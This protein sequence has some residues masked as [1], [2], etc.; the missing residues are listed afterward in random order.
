[1]DIPQELYGLD[2]LKIVAEN[3]WKTLEFKYVFFGY[4]LKP[5]YFKVQTVVSMAEGQLTENF[6]Y[7]LEGTPCENVFSGKRVCIHSHGVARK[8]PEDEMLINMGVES[9]IGAPTVV[10][11]KLFGLV[12]TL[13]PE[14]IID[15][16]FYS[17][18]LEF[19]AARVSVEL[20]RY[21]HKH[22]LEILRS[23]AS[24]DSLTKC[25]NRNSF[26]EAI[27]NVFFEYKNAS[28][29]FVDADHFKIVNDT[30]GHLY[31][32]EVLKFIASTLIQCV[33]ESDLVCRFGGEEFVVYLPN[34]TIDG[35][36]K[37]GQRIHDTLLNNTDFNITVSIGITNCVNNDEV[38][39]AVNRADKAVYQAKNN[40]RNRTEVIL[41]TQV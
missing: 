9:Y 8:F 41:N 27:S 18:L 37:L 20:E 23:K 28:I 5:D 12:A 11:G 4:A 19:I 38:D 33:R 26:D 31:G 25:L 1:M 21:T 17:N 35:A 16:A 32:D 24:I 22:Q 30:H 15:E 13:D 36:K 2:Y 34:V 7:D 14:K 10:E 40:G 39:D 29:M 6:I 3:I